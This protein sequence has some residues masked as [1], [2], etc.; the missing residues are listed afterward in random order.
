MSF[1]NNNYDSLNNSISDLPP[2]RPLKIRWPEQVD[3]RGM[4]TPKGYPLLTFPDSRCCLSF[5]NY[6]LLLDYLFQINR[7]ESDLTTEDNLTITRP[8]W[9]I[10]VDRRQDRW[11]SVKTILSFLVVGF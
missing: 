5:E 4:K 9:I 10:I 11:S 8:E 7:E 3:D 6:Q 1:D 2:P